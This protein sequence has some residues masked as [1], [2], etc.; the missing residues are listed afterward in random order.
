LEQELAIRFSQQT[1]EVR[2]VRYDDPDWYPLWTGYL[3][4]D[5]GHDKS[6]EFALEW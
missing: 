3:P 1:K 4:I 2:I 6:I 5:D